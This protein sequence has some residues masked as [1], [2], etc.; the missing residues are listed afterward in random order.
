LQKRDIDYPAELVFKSVFRNRD[1]IL[2]EIESSLS[3]I[4]IDATIRIRESGKS[5]FISYTIRAVFSSDEELKKACDRISSI[6]GFMMM[7]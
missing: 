4:G 2:G 5:T 1:D 6:E 7:F 3:E